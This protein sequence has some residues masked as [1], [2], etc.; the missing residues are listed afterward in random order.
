MLYV[1]LFVSALLIALN[2]SIRRHFNRL[3]CAAP[4]ATLPN[5]NHLSSSE[6]SFFFWT[7]TRRPLETLRTLVRQAA[8][9]MRTIRSL[10]RKSE[11]IHAGKRCMTM[12]VAGWSKAV[13]SAAL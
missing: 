1:L 13:K 6:S 9:E 4:G 12:T 3:L 5:T 7:L 2:Y 11:G 8:S 10:T